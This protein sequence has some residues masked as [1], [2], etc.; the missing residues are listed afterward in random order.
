[1]VDYV[2]KKNTQWIVLEFADMG[3]L[4]QYISAFRLAGIKDEMSDDE[5]YEQF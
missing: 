3:D 5:R 4:D 2:E 1:M